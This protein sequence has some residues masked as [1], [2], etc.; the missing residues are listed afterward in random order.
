[1]IR[2][3]LLGDLHY[4]KIDKK[5]D[6]LHE[7]AEYFYKNFLNEFLAVDADWHVSIG[8]LTHLGL[9][10]EFRE[11]Y[12]LIE[13]SQ[14]KFQFALGNHDVL[15]LTK[16]NILKL[17]KQP[18]YEAIETNE[19]M[20]L[21]LDTTKELQ[22]HGWGLDKEQWDWLEIQ[23]SRS[24]DKPLLIF[25][26]HPVPN[27]TK[28]SPTDHTEFEPLQDIR[29]LLDRREG[30]LLYFN[31]H[32]HTQSIVQKGNSHFIQTGA[33]LCDSNYM[34]IELEDG[35]III[36]LH[37]ID[38]DQLGASRDILYKKLKDYHRPQPNIQQDLK[39]VYHIVNE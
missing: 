34:L 11:I 5:E 6:V 18:R 21:F 3:A 38:D 31:G 16:E 32:T 24:K 12:K 25:A 4:P 1:M 23:I 13:S 39:L 20:L 26:H 37:T 36:Y 9:E 17:V 28:D 8:D 29:P 7:A 27:T 30:L 15:S 35:E 19:C 10:D 22:L 2:I 33:V 14:V